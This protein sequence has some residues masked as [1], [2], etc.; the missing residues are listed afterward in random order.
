MKAI[1]TTDER[2]FSLIKFTDTYKVE[3]WLNKSSLA[4][5]E[6]I[7]LGPPHYC[8]HLDQEDVKELMPYLQR[9]IETGNLV[10][11]P[12]PVTYNLIWDLF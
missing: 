4:T 12:K 10:E 6:C 5:K 9:F 8:L 2:G 3:G 7:W 1:E 11:H